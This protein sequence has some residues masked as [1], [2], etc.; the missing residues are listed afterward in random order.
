MALTQLKALRKKHKMTQKQLANALGIDNSSV[1]KY[2]TGDVL[3]SHDILI[4]M[5]ELFNVSTDYILDRSGRVQDEDEVA[6][7]FADRLKALRC[8]SGI[9]QF[10][11]AKQL[12]MSQQAVA[13]W[14][15]GKSEPS[16][17]MLVNLA[18]FF[19]TTTDFLTGVND[20]SIKKAPAEENAADAQEVKVQLTQ[21][22]E[23]LS[24]LSPEQLDRYMQI[25][26]LI[27]Q[28]KDR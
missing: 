1:C 23:N 17:E 22:F 24:K 11:L 5:A 7:T 19:H 12:N 9:S 8:K 10:E 15:A 26:K 6:A 14:E 18:E 4:K 28:D 2:E 20:R 27:A 16:I 13:Q 21:L 3:P 25:L